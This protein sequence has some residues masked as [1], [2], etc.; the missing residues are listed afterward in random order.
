M[1]ADSGP[2]SDPSGR[3][4]LA[5]NVQCPKCNTVMQEKDYSRGG[6]MAYW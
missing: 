1:I 2:E 3:G 6:G 5:A 4:L